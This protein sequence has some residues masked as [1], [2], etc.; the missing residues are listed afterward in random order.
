MLGC[1][2]ECVSVAHPV[3]LMCNGRSHMLGGLCMLS[4]AVLTLTGTLHIPTLCVPGSFLHT[5]VGPADAQADGR[6]ARP[7]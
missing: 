2:P 3:P 4:E 5:G 7:C 6:S 1:E